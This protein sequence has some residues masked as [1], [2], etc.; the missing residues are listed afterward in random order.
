VEGDTER[1]RGSMGEG[2]EEGM[3]TRAL[4]VLLSTPI[5]PCDARLPKVAK[6]KI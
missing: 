3:V 1:Q 4:A 5:T 2:I 6:I